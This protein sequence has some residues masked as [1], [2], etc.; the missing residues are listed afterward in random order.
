MKENT[1]VADL[2]DNTSEETNKT[3]TGIKMPKL[4]HQWRLKPTGIMA[5]LNLAKQI[6]SCSRPV[7]TFAEIEIPHTNEE[8]ITTR[9]YTAGKQQ[10][11]ALTI[12]V[13]DD[14]TG[15]AA[16]VIQKQMML[17]Q[18]ALSTNFSDYKFD[19]D[20]E[21]LDGNHNVTDTWTIIGCWLQQVNYTSLDYSKS[22]VVQMELTIRYDH[23]IMND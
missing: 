13:E 7:V 1:T 19:I 4:K 20:I 15:D 11:T 3:D 8:G 22:E 6:I 5:D 18:E 12:V 16:R 2:M 9:S 14:A 23:A 10:W 21:Y 17:Q